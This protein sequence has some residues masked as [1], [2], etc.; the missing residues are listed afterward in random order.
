[1]DYI[2]HVTD[3]LAAAKTEFQRLLTQIDNGRSAI[4]E[5]ESNALRLSGVIEQY[6]KDLK[7]LEEHKTNGSDGLVKV[8]ESPKEVSQ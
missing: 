2:K 6:T 7:M 8:A 5:M 4:K 1:M 3:Q